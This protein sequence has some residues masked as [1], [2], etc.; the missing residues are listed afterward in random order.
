VRVA[1][2]VDGLEALSTFFFFLLFLFFEAD[3]GDAAERE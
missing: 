1:T 2:G 3:P